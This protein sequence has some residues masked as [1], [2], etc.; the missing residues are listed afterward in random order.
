MTIRSLF[1]RVGS[2]TGSWL[3]AVVRRKRLEIE[4]EVELAQHLDSLTADLIRAGQSPAEAA[5]RAR[6]ALG[7]ALVHKEEMRAS[8]G[9]RWWDALGADVRYGARML[10]K[11]PGF[12]LVAT[13]SLALAIGANTTIFSLAKQLLYERLN[14]PH[15]TDLRLLSWTAGKDH[16]AVHH[17]WG[18]YDPLP[19]GRVTSTSFSYPA[20]RLLRDQNHSLEDLFA[21][22]LTGMNATVHNDAQRVQTEM[23]SGNY[24]SAL[25]VRPQLGRA[26]QPSDDAA[27]GQGAV[28]VI[29]DSFWERMF[30]RS[31]SALG[32]VIKL[33]DTPLTIIGVNPKGFTGAK[34][35][36]QS[37]DIFVPLSMQPL[38]HPVTTK[39]AT[40]ANGG[41]AYSDALGDPNFWWVNVMGHK[42]QGVS[43]ATAQAVLN[44]Q[45]AAIVRGTM[46][47]RKNEGIPQLDLRDGSRGLFVQQQTF[48]KPMAV[49]M[50]LVGFVLL[51]ACANVAN[52]MLA[53]GAQR[54]REMSVRLALGAGRIRILR[55][56]LVESLLLASLGGA[57]GILAGYLGS[58]IL[59]KLTENAWERTE[60]HVA[61]DW[62]VFAFT[63]AVT[64]ITGLLFGMAPALAAARS[65]VSHGLKEAAQ[66]TSRRRSGMSG[67][68]LVGFQIALST[69]LVIGAGLFLRTLAG[70]NAIDVGFRTENLLL[71]EINPPAN[72]Y[73]AGKDVALH[74]RLER[75]MASMAGV[76]SV[77]PATVAY[78]ADDTDG[79]DFLPEGEHYDATKH[80][81]EDFNVV[82][83]HFSETLGLPIVAGRG[84]GDQDTPGSPRVAVINQSLARTRYPGQNPVG[85]RFKTDEHDS[86]GFSGKAVDDWIQ[87][88]GVCAD[89][90]YA[91]LREDPP[92]QFILP[93]QQQPDVG[94]MAYEI[95][96]RLKPDAI[97]PA[98]R[99]AVRDVDPD[100]PVVNVRTEDQQI[101]ADMLQERIFVTFT[102][103][104]GILALALACVGIYG[105][106]A[107][108]VANRRNEIGIRMALGAQQMQVRV[109]ILRE[110]TW[111]AMAGI[112]AGVCASLALT[113]LVKTMLYGIQPYDPLT[114]TG[115]VLILLTVALAASWIPARRAARVQPMD[116]LRHE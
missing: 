82:G 114:I 28:A 47:V 13:L 99:R 72:R 73:P 116:A 113:R 44:G 24:Y 108:S 55:Q 53:R 115:G 19:G 83:N 87:I 66:T 26:I 29:S 51:L 112:V 17:T 48:A 69:V 96:T 23:V 85:K 45:L 68:A 71:A 50:T 100:L 91:N 76:D 110:S 52:L 20:Y 15:S 27:H 86:D 16:P 43:D 79:T 32:E 49:L 5:R 14:V 30:N 12:T 8:L 35:V 107:Y 78:L 111:L 46:P 81:E 21:F 105:I 56:M 3:R 41:I 103:G 65:E 39:A 58:G 75:A 33:N 95:R 61:F 104:F 70:L 88:V 34:N 40:L 1:G 89:T 25:D 102:S 7:S 11:S 36:Q 6:I 22:K 60:F 106:M 62:R 57:G 18:D 59:P 31:P 42:R 74:Q 4:M 97:L 92:P 67:K 93:Y 98:L 37:P 77:S 10:R 38:V 90:R 94:G 9:L 54:K 101:Q 109:M 80:Q 64:L 84:F 2:Q 63:A